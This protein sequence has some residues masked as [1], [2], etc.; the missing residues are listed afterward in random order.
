MSKL[1]PQDR[2]LYAIEQENG[3]GFELRILPDGRFAGEYF[4]GNIPDFFGGQVAWLSLQGAPDEQGRVP[5]L[6]TNGAVFGKP[7]PLNVEPV[8]WATF[9]KRDDG[10][11][12][13]VVHIDGP[14]DKF[15]PSEPQ[16]SPMV[17][18]MVVV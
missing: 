13:A 9:D 8:G 17:L 12:D 1:T 3:T 14:R 5:L 16:E 6:V 4:G 10:K 15:S 18:H 2:G 11:I 7:N